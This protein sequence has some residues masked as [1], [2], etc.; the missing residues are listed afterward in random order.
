M[1]NRSFT[2]FLNNDNLPISANK[3]IAP[4][5]YKPTG[6]IWHF[7][8]AFPALIFISLGVNIIQFA[9]PGESTECHNA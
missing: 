1:A 3:P 4:P 5:V 2:D 7:A 9:N 6:V 8:V